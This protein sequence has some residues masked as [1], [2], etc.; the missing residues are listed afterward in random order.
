[1]QAFLLS[2][3]IV[4]SGCSEEGNIEEKPNFHLTGTIIELFDSTALI[5]SAHGNIL[6]DLSVNDSTDFQVNDQVKVGYDGQ[7]MESDPAQ[8]KTLSVEKLE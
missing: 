3:L 8:I 4:S 6:I 2:M 5:E 7:I 1:M